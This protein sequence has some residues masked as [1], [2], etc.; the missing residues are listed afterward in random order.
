MNKFKYKIVNFLRIFKYANEYC[1]TV[2]EECQWFGTAPYCNGQCP[3]GSGWYLA[4]Q[5]SKGDGEE[6]S[7]P[8]QKAYCCRHVDY[9]ESKI[10]NFIK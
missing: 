6:C 1:N 9:Q 8:T 5:G 2:K 4:M 3:R 7:W 10:C